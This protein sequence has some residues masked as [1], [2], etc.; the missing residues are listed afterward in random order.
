M[1]AD[2]KTLGPSRLRQLVC[3]EAAASCWPIRDCNKLYTTT[4]LQILHQKGLMMLKFTFS[5]YV[6]SLEP[7]GSFCYTVFL[8][9]FSINFVTLACLYI[10]RNIN[11]ASHL[12]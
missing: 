10:F 4:I 8:H 12:N 7:F 1:G 11:A 5:Q 3:D 2:F 9:C 6:P